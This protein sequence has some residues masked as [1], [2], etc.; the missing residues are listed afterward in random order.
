MALFGRRVRIGDLLVSQGLITE[1]QLETALEE[2][3]IRKTKLGETLMALGYISQQDF[4]DVL[5]KAGEPDR[6]MEYLDVLTEKDKSKFGA[7]ELKMRIALSQGDKDE[8]S[9]ILAQFKNYNEGFD[10]AY[11]LEV[12]FLRCTGEFEKAKLLCKEALEDYDSVP[13]LH[14]QLALL[15]LIDGDYDN[16]FEEAFA[17]DNNAYYLYAY[18][19][20][21]SAYTPQL[22][23]TLYLCTY[24]CK[25][26]GKKDTENAQYIDDILASFS[27]EDLTEQV[28]SIIG[29][30]KTVEEVLTEG[31]CDLA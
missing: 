2:Q 25:E 29:G 27:E 10:T 9:K 16:A 5:Y 30:E 3:K 17:A 6:A 23:S 11:V 22:N 8:A 28:K 14:R 18:M 13:E 24:L 7:Y 21:S 26:S 12:T 4:A 31:G 20:D 19:G 1:K 15:Y